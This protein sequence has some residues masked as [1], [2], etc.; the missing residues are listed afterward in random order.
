MNTVIVVVGACVL[1]IIIGGMAG[2]AFAKKKF[3]GRDLI[4]SILLFTL[5]VP[6]QATMI[7]VFITMRDLGLLNSYIAL[8]LPIVNVFSVF[9]MRQFMIRIPDDLLEAARIDGC[10]EFGIFIKIV[11]PSVKT[12]MLSLSIFTFI[13]AWNDFLW[14]L[15]VTTDNS[16]RTLTLA[17]STLQGNYGTNY[18]IIMAGATLVF[19]PPFIFYV[20]LQ[21][22]F[23]EGVTM[24]GIK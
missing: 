23:V 16:M 6:G 10:S 13:T 11:L 17:L 8:T 20:F 19:I 3:K 22:K 15:V 2:Y 9:F 14:P 7:P 5:M 24:T 4:F 21:K 1:N 18:G 12:A